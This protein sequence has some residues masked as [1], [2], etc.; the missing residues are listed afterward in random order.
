MAHSCQV[1]EFETLE[2]QYTFSLCLAI[3]VADTFTNL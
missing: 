2:S 3:Y 1:A